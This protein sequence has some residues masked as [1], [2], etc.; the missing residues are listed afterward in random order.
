MQTE[1]VLI[2]SRFLK[3]FKE[4]ISSLNECTDLLGLASQSMESGARG[5]GK[6]SCF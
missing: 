5:I 3:V 1:R 4:I 2:K 6:G